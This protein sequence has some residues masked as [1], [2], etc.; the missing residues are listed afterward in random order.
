MGTNSAGSGQAWAQFSIMTLL[1]KL[2]N[3][4]T[5]SSIRAASWIDCRKSQPTRLR[6]SAEHLDL[7]RRIRAQLLHWTL[8][9]LRRF[10]PANFFAM[11]PQQQMRLGNGFGFARKLRLQ[12]FLY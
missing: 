9:T 10:V 4:L 12:C 8:V 5:V 6:S 7:F 2:Q 11:L 1:R 3:T